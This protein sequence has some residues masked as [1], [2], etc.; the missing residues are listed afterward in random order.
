MEVSLGNN[1]TKMKR[2]KT[3][4]SIIALTLFTLLFLKCEGENNKTNNTVIG[5]AS[6]PPFPW[7]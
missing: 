1:Y 2:Q 5:T 7:E 4:L 3:S 6:S